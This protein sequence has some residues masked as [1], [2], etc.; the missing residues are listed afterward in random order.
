MSKHMLK[1]STVYFM[2]NPEICQDEPC[3]LGFQFRSENHEKIGRSKY[4]SFGKIHIF[5]C[6]VHLQCILRTFFMF[7]QDRDL[8]TAY[9]GIQF[10]TCDFVCQQMA[11][12]SYCIIQVSVF[13]LSLLQDMTNDNSKF[14][15]RLRNGP[16]SNLK[17]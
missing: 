15:K 4:G 16:E 12:K 1:F 5:L 6:A 2:R 17:N 13:L 3:S 9:K 7:N 11:L 8:K 10:L 14:K